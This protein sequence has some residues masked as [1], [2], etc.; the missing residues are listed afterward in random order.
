MRRSAQ[1]R[2]LASLAFGAHVGID[3]LNGPLNFA[4]N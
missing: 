1:E 2:A 4:A 3:G